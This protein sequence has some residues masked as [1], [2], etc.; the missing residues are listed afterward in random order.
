MQEF[1]R[2]SLN[3]S[4][5]RRWN[6]S[7][8]F[9]INN[10][11]CIPL[12]IGDGISDAGSRLGGFPPVGVTPRHITPSTRY[13]CT[14]RIDEEPVLEVSIFIS[15]D[16]DRM[17]DNAGIIQTEGELFE[18]ITHGESVRAQN[19]AF[20]SEL[21][22]HPILPR[23]MC[24]DYVVDDEGSRF[25]RSNHKLGGYPFIQDTSDGL[26][27]AVGKAY[28]EAYFQVLQIDFPGSDDGNIDGD[29]PFAGGIFHLLGREPLE[30][31]SWRCFWEY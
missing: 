23:T 11:Y 19:S 15:F 1:L 6:M 13:F 10:G 25:V 4:Q 29:W 30:E 22:P 14:I 2:V 3:Q 8:L 28:E 18:V 31:C 7:R 9:P 24:D 16:F 12:V 27:E 5:K 17:A 20:K 26:P 21:T